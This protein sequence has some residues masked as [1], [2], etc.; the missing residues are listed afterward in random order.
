MSANKYLCIIADDFGMH[1]AVN[2]G[3]V[4]AFSEGL[5]TDTN[6]MAPTPAFRE[7]VELTKAHEIPVGLHA[8]FTCDWDIY[9][10][11]PLTEAK[12]FVTPEGRLKD[13]VE[14]AWKHGIEEDALIELRE[15]YRVIKGE[16]IHMNHVGQHMG[17]DR[18]GK[19]EKVM[20]QLTKEE[21]LP[22]KGAPKA[23]MDF[24]LAYEW[25]SGFS[26]GGCLTVE[27][28]KSRL[29]TILESL[30][31]GYH[32]WVTHPGIDHDSLDE[33]CTPDFHARHWART[34]RAIDL[35]LLLDKEIADV[36]GAN[37]I[38]IT[39]LAECPIRKSA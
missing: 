6:L 11:G 14:E 36:V 29:K 13:S 25:S 10:W 20:N 30:T 22:Y 23:E 19:F 17:R 21:G 18:G 38:E 16:G 5:L 8:T 26:S 28:G 31:P 37:G 39:P 1:P 27:E 9:S 3:I 7:A 4:K 2:E 15:Q 12:S 35:A 32:A 24:A 33:L 34:F